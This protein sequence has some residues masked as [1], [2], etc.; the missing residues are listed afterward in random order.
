VSKSLLHDLQV[1]STGE[2]PGGNPQ[3]KRFLVKDYPKDREFRR[4]KLSAQIVAKLQA[5]VVEHGLGRDDLL[6]WA[7][8]PDGPQVRKLRLVVD[9]ET[10]GLTEPNAVG[11]RYGTGR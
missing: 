4:F 2:Q 9:S 3:G 1:S 10:L 6:F 8:E 11:R 5:H 7:P